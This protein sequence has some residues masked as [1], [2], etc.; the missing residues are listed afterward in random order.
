MKCLAGESIS[1]SVN[2]GRKWL[3]NLFSNTN[4]AEF[5]FDNAKASL[6]FSREG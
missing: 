5:R 2:L 1:V 3:C 4:C 6:H